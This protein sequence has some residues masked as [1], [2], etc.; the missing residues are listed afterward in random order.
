MPLSPSLPPQTYNLGQNGMAQF[1]TFISY[2]QAQNWAA[3]STDLQTATRWC[4]Q[5]GNRCTRD[6]GI[7]ANG[8]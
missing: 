3:A 8:C 2:I 1:T 5:V 6:A 7:I 4:G